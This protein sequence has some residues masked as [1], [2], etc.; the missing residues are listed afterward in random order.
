MPASANPPERRATRPAGTMLRGKY[1][2][3]RV[4]GAGG[5]ATVYAA[6]HRNGH[7]VAIKMLHEELSIRGDTR[8][9]FQREGYVANEVGHAGAVRVLDDDVA[10]NGAAFLVMEL[11]HGETLRARC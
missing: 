6:V 10:E 4:L 9:R 2:I 5:M 3:E 7:R 8:A 1:R 11:L